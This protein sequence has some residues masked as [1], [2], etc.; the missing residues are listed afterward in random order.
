MDHT[1][2]RKKIGFGISLQINRLLC[3]RIEW[4][5]RLGHNEAKMERRGVETKSPQYRSRKWELKTDFNPR[6]EKADQ[7]IC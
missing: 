7:V 1:T 4:T 2:Q 6:T 3:P 5:L